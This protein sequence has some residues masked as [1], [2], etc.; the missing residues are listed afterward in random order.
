MS[1]LHVVPFH[2]F[3]VD[4]SYDPPEEATN[5][6]ASV[7]VREVF[8]QEPQ[9]AEEYVHSM[10]DRLLVRLSHG[11]APEWLAAEFFHLPAVA[12]EFDRDACAYLE[13][14]PDP[15]EDYE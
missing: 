13:P 7:D 14:E 1:P 11:W 10:T 2:G 12:D 9:E 8:I 15:R 5:C 3:T 6:G 4:V